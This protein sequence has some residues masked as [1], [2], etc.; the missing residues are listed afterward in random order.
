MH[1]VR[2]PQ[3]TP[4]KGNSLHDYACLEG[5]H[6]PSIDGT[7]VFGASPVSSKHGCE[8][9]PKDGPGYLHQ[10]SLLR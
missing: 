4:Q 8:K 5:A 3:N 6:L 2:S 7:G 1:T 9:Q 10:Q